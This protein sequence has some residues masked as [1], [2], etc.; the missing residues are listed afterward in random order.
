MPRLREARGATSRALPRVLLL[1]AAAL[2]IARIGSGVWEREHPPAAVER[3]SWRPIEAAL[4]EA[5]GTRKPILYEFSAAWCGPCKA[6]SSEVFADERSPRLLNEWFVPVRVVD[7][8][9]EQGR[10][11]A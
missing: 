11:P 2:L 4:G 10:N 7:V 6:M 8:Q 9:R 3:L 1:I 5:G